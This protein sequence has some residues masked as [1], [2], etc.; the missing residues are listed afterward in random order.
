MRSKIAAA[1]IATAAGASVL[2]ANGHMLNPIA[3]IG[4]SAKHTLFVPRVGPAA[5]RKRWIAGGL[6]AQGS[7]AIDAGAVAALQR[8]KSLLPVGVISAEG[9]FDRGD[10]VIVR[11]SDGRELARGLIAYNTE[12]AR[13]LMG[14]RTVEIEAILGYRGRDEMIHRDDLAFTGLDD[15]EQP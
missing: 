15:E 7:I 1:K 9:A 14:R 3:A 2:I 4:S 11:D 5:A 6:T 10:A 13:R 12:E 8:G